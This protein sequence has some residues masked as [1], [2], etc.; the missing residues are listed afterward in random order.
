[1]IDQISFQ[2]IHVRAAKFFNILLQTPD[3]EIIKAALPEA[4]ERIVAARKGQ[5]K[6][7]GS[8]GL[9]AAQASRDAL[10]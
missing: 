9:L 6:L 7:S 8:I 3:I 10:L 1:M 5:A 4:A 2:R